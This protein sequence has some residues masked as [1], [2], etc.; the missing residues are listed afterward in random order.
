MFNVSEEI[1]E[2]TAHIL[3]EIACFQLRLMSAGKV[4][5]N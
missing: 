5:D 4:L 2:M 3:N 1:N